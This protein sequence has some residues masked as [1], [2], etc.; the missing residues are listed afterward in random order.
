MFKGSV[1][2]IYGESQSEKSKGVTGNRV[3]TSACELVRVRLRESQETECQLV[4]VN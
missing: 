2:A 4:R 3:S 1:V